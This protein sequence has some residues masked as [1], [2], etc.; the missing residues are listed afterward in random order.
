MS[1]ITVTSEEFYRGFVTWSALEDAL[2]GLR[3]SLPSDPGMIERT[4]VEASNQTDQ[5]GADRNLLTS[6]ECCWTQ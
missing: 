5:V 6:Y 1:G 2:N 4:V 3:D